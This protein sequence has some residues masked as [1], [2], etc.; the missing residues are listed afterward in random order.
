MDVT[1]MLAPGLQLRGSK[2]YG[3]TPARESNGLMAYHLRSARA[4]TVFVGLVFALALFTLW[5]EGKPIWGFWPQIPAVVV[6]H[7][8]FEGR[9]GKACD[10]ALAY[11]VGGQQVR[12][13][14]TVSVPCAEAPPVGS[15]VTVRHDQF[16][17][18][19]VEIRGYPR[20]TG[21]WIMALCALMFTPLA[22]LALFLAVAWRRVMTLRRL[23]DA[24]WFEFTGIVAKQEIVG[25]YLLRLTLRPAEPDG[26]DID[27]Q[28]GIRPISF[29]PLPHTGDS[30]TVRLAGTGN[31]QVLVTLPDHTGEAFG[32]IKTRTS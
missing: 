16:D 27:L 19:W 7:D 10:V 12:S 14:A 4:R 11:P 5:H 28:F 23:G 8:E 18:G 13:H 9:F 30:F 20:P 6:G 22:L 1:I 21:L 31:G 2:P 15:S 24:P 29:F 26:P 3:D 32:T 17:Y 25:Q